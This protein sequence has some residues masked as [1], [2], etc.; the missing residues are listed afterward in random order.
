MLARA[1]VPSA[2]SC[3]LHASNAAQYAGKPINAA[4]MALCGDG[5]PRVDLDQVIETM[6]VVSPSRR[7]SVER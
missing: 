3:S 6:R 2:D 1:I 7:R 5:L 4:R